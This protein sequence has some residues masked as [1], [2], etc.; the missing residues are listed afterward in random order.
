MS[1][2][3]AGPTSPICRLH[4]FTVATH[5]KL[6]LQTSLTS[7]KAVFRHPSERLSLITLRK[8]R[9]WTVRRRRLS[10][11]R[12]DETAGVKALSC[13][14]STGTSNRYSR[15]VDSASAA[16]A[17]CTEIS[18]VMKIPGSPPSHILSWLSLSS[19][20]LPFLFCVVIYTEFLSRYPVLAPLRS[21]VGFPENVRIPYACAR[22]ELEPAVPVIFFG[23]IFVR[24]RLSAGRH[25]AISPTAASTSDQTKAGA[26]SQV[27]S[28][29]VTLSLSACM[30]SAEIAT[31]N[32]PSA[33]MR[34]VPTRFRSDICSLRM[35]G[36]G[37]STTKR[38]VAVL[39]P[40]HCIP[41][42]QRMP[43]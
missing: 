18:L 27:V 22:A 13:A 15:G 20:P 34:D 32:K 29:F 30:R 1:T 39:K 41:L 21:A 6:Q 14:S 12:L 4:A 23:R 25:V 28:V 17:D 40:A 31:M 16:F 42:A 24:G 7:L 3:P 5:A 36:I 43:T 33:K 38:S 8:C 11:Q 10:A 26:E 35:T 9:A 19:D 2:R 37:S